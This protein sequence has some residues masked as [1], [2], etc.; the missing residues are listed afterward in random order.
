MR[1]SEITQ[2]DGEALSDAVG[3]LNREYQEL[4]TAG[5]DLGTIQAPDGW[6]GDAAQAA[7]GR[8]GELID[9]LRE[10]TGEIA[11]ARA[12]FGQAGDAVNGVKNGARE[13]EE[14]AKANNFSITDDGITDHGVPEDT[15][16]DQRE[17][18]AE[19]RERAKV[20]LQER[21]NAVLRSAR[22]VD[23]DLCQVLDEILGDTVDA[24]SDA[25]SL[26]GAG[27]AGAQ[28]GDLSIPEPPS[29]NN[30]TAAQNAAWWSTLSHAQRQQVIKEHPGQVG[31]RDG[32]PAVARSEANMARIGQERTRIQGTID[33]LKAEKRDH[34]GPG[35]TGKR[36]E[37]DRQINAAEEKLDS[38]DAVEQSMT[39]RRD[40]ETRTDRQL[41]LLDTSGDRL[42]AAVSN[43][44]VD[45]ADHVAVFTP[46]MN[47]TVNGSLNG[48]LKDTEALAGH[49]DYELKREGREGQNIATVTWVGYEPPMSDP[50]GIAEAMLT[51]DSAEKG[52][53]DLAKFYNGINSSRSEDPHM[54]ALGHSWGSLTQGIALRDHQTGVDEAG[55]F[56]S[57]GTET[58][59]GE[60]LNVPDGHAYAWEAERDAIPDLP[61]RYGKDV[62]DQQGIHHMSTEEWEPR[63]GMET[64]GSTGHSEY[65][66]SEAREEGQEILQT[67][68]YAMSR[69]IIGSPDFRVVPE[70]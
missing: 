35:G 50:G 11:A 40:G 47:S 37:L 51:D 6:S 43:G 52:S 30:A 39:N 36:M 24:D 19:E 9:A 57:P 12:A 59:S 27:K 64:E 66:T 25:T 42:K 68:E 7:S 70:G 15:P 34:A 5:E 2:W 4:T 8:C 65:M 38:L 21:V 45:T 18:V 13:A 14:F 20:E 54:T 33:K 63:P 17:A 32:V 49:A 69:I 55:F 60:Q 67:S 62:V 61:P 46:G 26:S 3:P 1:W 48:Y 29:M 53:E 41:M 16:K 23:R 44:N 10:W 22:D 56:G 31:N 28:V 58:R